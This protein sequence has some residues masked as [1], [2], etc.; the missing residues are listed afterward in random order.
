[1]NNYLQSRILWEVARFRVLWNYLRG[2]E[3]RRGIQ[4]LRMKESNGR[5]IGNNLKRTSDDVR[6]AKEI[7]R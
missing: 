3:G 7:I 1:M 5:T 4:D 2:S 6:G